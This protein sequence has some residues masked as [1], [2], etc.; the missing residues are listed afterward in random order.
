VQ[1]A[2]REIKNVK[3][4]CILEVYK[5]NNLGKSDAPTDKMYKPEVP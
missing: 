4:A 5:V 3:K 1:G 2:K